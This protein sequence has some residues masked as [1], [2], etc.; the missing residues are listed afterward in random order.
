MSFAIILQ[1]ALLLTSVKQQAVQQIDTG[2]LH[3]RIREWAYP[4]NRVEVADD[5]PVL[6]WPGVKG[7]TVKYKVLLSR[8]SL[9][10]NNLIAGNE[11]RWA[12]YPLH[13][14]LKPGRWF[15]KYAS[16]DKAGGKWKWSPVYDFIVKKQAKNVGV[17]PAIATIL[18]KGKAAHPRLWGMNKN[19]EAFYINNKQNPEAKS[20]IS[21]STKLIG[22]PLP[23]EKPT[24]P[25]DTT[26][27]NA[28]QRKQ[29]IEFMYHGFGEKVGAPIRNLCIA[30]QLTKDD[31]FIK[32]AIKQA[33]HVAKMNP[34]GYATRDDFNN[35]NI[36][37]SI[38]WLYDAGFKYLTASEKSLLK[39][40]IAVRG[41]RIYEDLPNRFELQMCDNHVWQHIL[42]NF[43]IAA[44]AVAN[45]LPEADEWLTYVYEVWS[46]RFPVLGSTDGGWHEGNGYFRTHY[47][48]LIYLPELFGN[49]SGMDY[50]K[51]TWMKNLPYYMLYSYPPNSTSTAVGDMHENLAGTVKMQAKFAEA[52]ALKVDNPFLNWYVA[53]IRK[54][55]PEFFKGTDDFVLFRLLNYN[56]KSIKPLSAPNTLAKGRVFK[57]I[58]LVAMHSNLADPSKN[59]G[60]YLMSNPFGAA[61]H[62]HA[63]Q[64]AFTIN[65]NGKKVFGGT[66]FYSNFSDA[67]NLL[68]YR[69]SRAYNTILADSLG[70]RIGEDGYGWIPRFMTGNR[71]QYA[72]GDASNA[73][74]NVT[75]D[76]WL[77]RFKQIGLKADKSSGYGDSGVKLYRRHMLQLDSNY[78]ILYDE[79]EAVKPVK[80]TSQMHSPFMMDGKT[81]SGASEQSFKLKTNLAHVSTTVYAHTPLKLVLHDKYN[82][83]AKNWK[84]KTDDEGNIIEFTNQWHAGITTVNPLRTN[85]FLTVIQLKDKTV[86]VIKVIS[87]VNGLYH[88]KVGPWEIKA[89]LNASDVASLIVKSANENAVFGYGSES[90]EI[91]GHVYKHS[92]DG[93]SILIETKNNSINKQE[94]VDSLPD[95]VNFDFGFKRKK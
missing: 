2:M 16:S 20:F 82:F 50:F 22:Q 77:D 65:Y 6:L 53:E 47:E 56:P 30:F 88:L 94:V 4:V 46:A 91:K 5:S 14:S 85:R 9:F 75:T 67:H 13:Q 27:M 8:D 33:V 78:V 7:K 59:L 17:S 61:G 83:P 3:P 36:L 11:Q 18:E 89:A 60:S 87:N 93:S 31:R 25:R 58:G 72:L 43:S 38:A 40:T 71:I 54:T 15:W 48:T 35:G 1:S 29:M 66:G 90:L 70:Q 34:D 24:R 86:D 64:N 79:L 63:A 12:V 95:V 45:D 51:Q 80:W 73:Y 52:L 41:Q 42:R 92:I 23:E 44:V 84:G 68:D 76:F 21:A 39:H 19:A 26:G 62:G 69:S 32:E 81:I 10:K 28:L 37:E 49:I 55:K 57:D 74:G